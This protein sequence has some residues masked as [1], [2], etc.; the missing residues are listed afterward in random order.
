M[1]SCR[2]LDAAGIKRRNIATH[3][4]RHAVYSLAGEMG[5]SE[6]LIDAMM[7]KAGQTVSAGYIHID[8]SART[9]AESVQRRIWTALT[10][11]EPAPVISLTREGAG[12]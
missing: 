6:L 12:A 10:R 9:V 3:I 5:Y 1:G 4:F 7:G 11:A 8:S 2:C